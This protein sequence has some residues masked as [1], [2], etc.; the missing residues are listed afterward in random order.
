MSAD[1]TYV[2]KLLIIGEAGV[3]KSALCVRY[4]EGTFG[5]FGRIGIDF[6]VHKVRIAS[7]N[8]KLQLW[9]TA[10]E[11]RFRSLNANYYRGAAGIF[12][13]FDVTC[14]R[15]FER[16]RDWA[17]E[18]ISHVPDACRILIGNKS[19]LESQRVIPMEMA[20]KLGEEFQMPYIECSAK[21]GNN[22][23][24]AFTQMATTIVD[25]GIP[26]PIQIATPPPPTTAPQY[27]C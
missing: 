23:E 21:N 14:Q 13:V 15:S 3:G 16:C 20:Q 24:S 11:E 9:D 27:C 7:T 17:K 1:C 4:T 5:D 25:R 22:V 12:I 2:C 8:L 19:D 18:A 10:G 26:L 6:K